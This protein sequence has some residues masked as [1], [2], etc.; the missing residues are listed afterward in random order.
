MIKEWKGSGLTERERDKQ[1]S[2]Q[3]AKEQEIMNRIR[4]ELPRLSST[5]LYL[6]IREIQSLGISR[7]GGRT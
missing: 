6:L 4:G 2:A 1:I 7:T 3:E 5:N